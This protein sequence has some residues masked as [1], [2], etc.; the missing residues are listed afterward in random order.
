MQKAEGMPGQVC[1]EECPSPG[2]EESLGMKSTADCVLTALCTGGMAQIVAMCS[3]S[4][5]RHRVHC[6]HLSGSQQCEHGI[7]INFK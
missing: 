7:M 5:L 2:A 1:V 4:L 3:T 6:V